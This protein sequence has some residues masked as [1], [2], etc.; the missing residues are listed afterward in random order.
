MGISR[1]SA[2]DLAAGR[3]AAAAAVERLLAAVERAVLERVGLAPGGPAQGTHIMPQDGAHHHALWGLQL[4]GGV[5]VARLPVVLAEIAQGCQASAGPQPSQTLLLPQ[6]GPR[7][8]LPIPLGLWPLPPT[9]DQGQHHLAQVEVVLP[10]VKGRQLHGS[11][12]EA[13][14]R[15]EGGQ[16]LGAC[17]QEQQ[18]LFWSREELHPPFILPQRP[19]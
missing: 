14:G 11:Q 7:L 17:G 16:G 10:H 8:R 1:S 15:L 4:V 9:L 19:F 5:D 13:G 18:V 2:L 12:A 6:Q 3:I